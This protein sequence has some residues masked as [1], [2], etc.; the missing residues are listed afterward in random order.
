MYLL[1][2]FFAR[3]S[4]PRLIAAIAVTAA[5]CVTYAQSQALLSDRGMEPSVAK[6]ATRIPASTPAASLSAAPLADMSVARDVRLI[7]APDLLPT[8]ISRSARALTAADL[9]GTWIMSYETLLQGGHSGGGEVI[10]TAASESDTYVIKNFWSKDLEVRFTVDPETGAVTIPNQV[11]ATTKDGEKVDVTSINHANGAPT[12]NIP[13]TGVVNADGSITIDTWWAVYLA[14]KSGAD[15]GMFDAYYNTRLVRPNGSFSFTQNGVKS[16]I[17]VRAEQ[18]ADN[19][20]E[21]TN[22]LNGGLTVELVLNSD[23]TATI[24]LQPIIASNNVVY[25]IC[26]AT[27]DADNKVS[28]S[29]PITTAAATDRKVISWT[30]WSGYGLN[31]DGAGSWLGMFTDGV[32]TLESEVTYPSISTTELNGEGT[33]ENP[34]IIATRD[35]LIYL[36]DM[37][38]NRESGTYCS[39]E[40]F[41]LANDIDMSGHRFTAIGKDYYHIFDGTFDGNGHTIKNLTEV[42][43]DRIYGGLF[44]RTGENSVISNLVIENASITANA[45]AACAVAWSAGDVKNVRVLTSVITNE[46]QGTGA[47]ANIVRNI[48]DSHAVGCNVNGHYGYTGGLLGQL[49]GTMERCSATDMRVVAG[50][51]ERNAMPAG[52]LVALANFGSAIRGSYFSGTIDASYNYTASYT[53]GIVGTC[54]GGSIER[55]FFVGTVRGYSSDAYTGGLVGLAQSVSLTDC[56][57]SGRVDNPASSR[58]GGLTGCLE[59]GTLNGEPV[60]G[61]VKRCYSSAAMLASVYLY[62]PET[63]RRELFGTIQNESVYTI[64]DCYF[65]NQLVNFGSTEYGIPTAELISAQGPAGLRNDAWFFAE[66]YNPRLKGL[67]LTEAALYSASTLVMAPNSN[68]NKLSQDATFDALGDTRFGYLRNGQIVTDGYFSTIDGN[69]I[70]LNEQYAIGVDTLFV[71]NGRAQYHLFLKIAPISFDGEGTKDSPY[72]IRTKDDLIQLSQ[73]T[74]KSGQTFPGTYFR[75]TND[76]DLEYSEDFLGIMNDVSS[77]VGFA[78][79]FDGDGHAVHKMKLH[80]LEWTTPPSATS[81]GTLN[82]KG[83]KMYQG[84]IGRL[85]GTG[86]VRN[87]TIASDCDI[88]L[89]ASSSPLV[90]HNTGL[91][92]NCRNYADV[93]TF[94]TYVG[95]I[96]GYNDNVATADVINCFNAGNITSGRFGAGGITGVNYNLV[97]NC[98]NTGTIIARELCTNYKPGPNMHQLMGGITGSMSGRLENCINYGTVSGHV[99]TGGLS[100]TM[101]S[102]SGS[103]QYKNDF[104][105]CINVGMVYCDE[106]ASCGALGGVSGTSGTVTGNYWDAQLLPLAA[107]ANTGAEGMNGVATSVLISGE[108]PESYDTEVWDFKAGEYPALKAFAGEETVAQARSIIV[109]IPAKTNA[110]D[111]TGVSAVLSQAE[112]MKW[113]LAKGLEFTIEGDR[114]NGPASVS[115]LATDT[116]YASIGSIVKPI[117]IKALPPMPLSGDGTESNPYIMKS[118]DD[119][120]ALARYMNQTGNGLDGSF[121]A[122][123][124]DIDFEGVEFIPL[125][126]DGVT[127]FTGTLDG[128]GHNVSGISYEATAVYQGA[129][130]TVGTTGVVKNLTLSGNITSAFVTTGGFTGRLYGRLENCVNAINVTSTKATAG[131]FTATAF[132]NAEAVDCINR[133]DVTAVSNAA[134]FAGMFDKASSVV[135]TRVSNEGTI[136]ANATKAYAAGIVGT[137]YPCKLTECSNSGVVTVKTPASQSYAAGIMAMAEGT[138]A[139][140]STYEIVDCTNSGAVTAASAVAGIVSDIK[141]SAGYAV[142]HLSGCTN[143]G[144]ITAKTTKAVSNTANAG[145]IAAVG[146]DAVITDCHNTGD[147]NVG[148]N[149]NTAGIAG[150][151]RV[152]AVAAHPVRISG[153]TNSGAV[154]GGSYDV[155]GIMGNLAA[156]STIDN[157]YNTGSVTSTGT[158]YATGGIA[159]ALTNVNASITNCWNTGNVTGATNRV[160]GIVGMNAQKAAITDCWNGGDIASVSQTQGLGSAAGYGIGGVAGQSA[161]VITRCYNYGTVKGAARVGG[162]VGAPIKDNTQITSCYNAGRIDAPADTCGNIVGVALVNNGT[163]WT[164]KNTIADTYYVTDFG[165]FEN[166]GSLG[167]PVTIAALAKTDMGEGW[168]IPADYSLPVAEPYADVDAALLYSAAVVLAE[169]DTYEKVTTV[170]NVGTPK[171]V[172]W[173]SSAPELSIEGNEAK[174]NASYTG[175][176]VLT[177]TSGN[178]SRT[179]VLQADARTSGIDGIEVDLDADAVYYD[180]QGVRVENPVPGRPYIVRSGDKTLKT[181]YR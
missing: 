52:G 115:S 109:D 127:Y 119:W 142:M 46:G 165:T 172:T 31:S 73:M 98:V 38:N 22:L 64:E 24:A 120:N 134:G 155:G 177:A 135:L 51:P 92:E 66:G 164:A 80:R 100:G 29:T 118:A 96:V 105:N 162:L 147:I 12:R 176:I 151:A 42:T 81:L 123:D 61:T 152:A 11:F 174:F 70:K 94:G 14:D 45:F 19:V 126:S 145:I 7:D 178:M 113:T 67:E 95:G 117:L 131:G 158:A 124:A 122:V 108:A 49:N 17:P 50:S 78:G 153:C 5:A 168:I 163:I 116:L 32:V 58:T 60:A 121:V 47:I 170:F 179:I 26:N 27:I 33:K 138:A 57:V 1:S 39:G 18:K 88:E 37:V 107:V 97:K 128:R 130:F 84:F 55:S 140:E 111:L 129:I 125:A 30:N 136:T 114:L 104:V 144:A 25:N 53:G 62:K 102:V 63:E 10:V 166:T 65:N 133:A 4:L 89:W 3:I 91:V 148:I 72:L 171:G 139:Y 68:V 132:D 106:A 173:T 40:Y 85:G 76:I 83:L 87:L 143:S 9:T 160:G 110:Y 15:G 93:L 101:A 28:F 137:A 146:P 103:F 156:Y 56:Y 54:A 169:G 150:Y 16:T 13:V 82:T 20:L 112:G 159:G 71:V 75:M 154:S 167:T 175:E 141:S 36:A 161:S 44:G 35:D 90:G 23:L 21:I 69:T 48:S 74:T 86:V 77:T 149:T 41:S 59:T 6:P 181:V 43:P 157:C 34:W 2:K 99:K 79:T 180:L 8:R